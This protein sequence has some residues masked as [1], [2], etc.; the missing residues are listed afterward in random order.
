MSSGRVTAIASLKLKHVFLDDERIEQHPNEVKTKFSK[1]IV[2]Y[3]FPVGD[4]LKDVFIEWVHFL[5]DE[6][7]CD[8]NT[9]LFPNT[10][11]SLDEND[12]FK[13][14]ALDTV[15][16]QST[17]PIRNIVKQA[18][19]AAGLDYYNPHLFR[20]TITHLG[21]QV[22]K[23]PEDFKAWSQNIGHSSP[24]TTFTSYGHIEENNQG[25]IIK[26]LGKNEDGKPIT[27]KDLNEILLLQNKRL[28][29]MK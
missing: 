24:L 21:Y 19:E 3:F 1:K 6:K 12:R 22:C 18:F 28:H 25:K 11:L 20:D 4:F 29:E 23:T 15:H 10:K 2:T 26:K 13:R 27:R 16:W 7:L 14:E 9:P 8:A 5:K 17:T